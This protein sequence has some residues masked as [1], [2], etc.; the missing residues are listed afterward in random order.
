MEVAAP[1]G[2]QG[3]LRLDVLEEANIG[4]LGPELEL[5]ATLARDEF[6]HLWRSH[7]A[8]ELGGNCGPPAG[9]LDH[10]GRVHEAVAEGMRHI[11]AHGVGAPILSEQIGRLGRAHYNVLH[12]APSEPGVRLEHQGADAGRDG[13]RGR[14]AR[15]VVGARVSD[16]GGGNLALVVGATAVGGG[17]RGRASLTIGRLVG[18]LWFRVAVWLIIRVAT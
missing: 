3:D 16:V 9:H 4:A 10:G 14:G 1:R 6:L 11:A 15:V 13:R 8:S 18:S 2:R 12:V 7:L 5:N 17:Q